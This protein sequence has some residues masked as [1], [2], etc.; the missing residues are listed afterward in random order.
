MTTF[1]IVGAAPRHTVQNMYSFV[2][3][4][5]VSSAPSSVSSGARNTKHRM[6][7]SSPQKSEQ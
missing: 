4:L 5:V 2:A 1:N 7:K 6:P 3:A